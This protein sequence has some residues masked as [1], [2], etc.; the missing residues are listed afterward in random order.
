[1]VRVAAYTED[2][3]GALPQEPRRQHTTSSAIASS[4]SFLAEQKDLAVLRR[5]RFASPKA[6]PPLQPK[7]IAWSGGKIASNKDEAVAAF[8]ARKQE[9]GELSPEEEASLRASLQQRRAAVVQT[10]AAV[11]TAGG[12]QSRLPPASHAPV[13]A[14]RVFALSVGG[15]GASQKELTETVRRHGG[16]VS[17]TVHKKVQYLLA[18]EQAVRRNTQAVR[19]ASLKFGIPIVR[20]SFV[21]S[22]VREGGLVDSAPHLHQPRVPARERAQAA[23]LST[24]ALPMPAEAMAD[25]AS[26][27]AEPSGSREGGEAE[28][29]EPRGARQPRQPRQSGRSGRSGRP[30][31]GVGGCPRRP[32]LLRHAMHTAPYGGFACLE[33]ARYRRARQKHAVRVRADA[34]RALAAEAEAF[35]LS[36]PRHAVSAQSLAAAEAVRRSRS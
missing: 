11:Q 13:L 18:S 23:A 16:V 20:Q 19:K 15:D 27:A 5:Q 29:A 7:R 33:L 12:V 30:P 17:R 1:M 6:A 14:G 28:E 22:C 4:G 26:L 35:R 31:A 8:I 25:V 32:G 2:L 34:R 36:R 3:S 9:T 24:A 21:E 10:T